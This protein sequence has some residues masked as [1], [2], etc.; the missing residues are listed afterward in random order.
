MQF[1]FAGLFL[2]LLLSCWLGLE[3]LLGFLLGFSTGLGVPVGLLPL[4]AGPGVPIS[5]LYCYYE[6]MYSR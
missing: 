1:V 6:G 3:C 2:E 4:L 5:L